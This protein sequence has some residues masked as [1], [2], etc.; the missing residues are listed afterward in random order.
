MTEEELDPPATPRAIRRLGIPLPPGKYLDDDPER[1][2]A[3]FDPAVDSL[4]DLDEFLGTASSGG[5][6]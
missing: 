3:E 5:A 6:H 1:P 4:E 2:V